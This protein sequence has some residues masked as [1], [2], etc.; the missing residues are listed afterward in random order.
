MDG[1][2]CEI[3]LR[4]LGAYRRI[5]VIKLQLAQTIAASQAIITMVATPR[6]PIGT[7]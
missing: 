5:L 4:P 3:L 7:S 6:N 2:A 1:K